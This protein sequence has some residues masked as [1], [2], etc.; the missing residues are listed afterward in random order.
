MGADLQS[1]IIWPS[2][3]LEYDIFEKPEL[4]V[5]YLWEEGSSSN[6]V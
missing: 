3:P 6:L 5:L 1:V 2:S 4:C